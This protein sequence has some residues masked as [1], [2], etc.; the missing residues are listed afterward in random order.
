MQAHRIAKGPFLSESPVPQDAGHF[1]V[2]KFTARRISSE[3][4]INPE[5]ASITVAPLHS[6]QELSVASLLARLP[7][8][9]M[10]FAPNQTIYNQGDS[11]TRVYVVQSGAV[12]LCHHRRNGQRQI[13][14]LLLPE[15][16]LALF[17]SAEYG[18]TAEATTYSDVLSYLRQDVSRLREQDSFVERSI[19]VYAG[20]RLMEMNGRLIS[21]GY[22]SAE[23]RVATFLL[24]LSDRIGAN[25]GDTIPLPMNRQDFADYLGLTIETVCRILSAMRRRGDITL[26]HRHGVVIADMPAL[27][28]ISEGAPARR[29]TSKPDRQPTRRIPSS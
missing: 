24:E 17:D 8:R 4:E 7:G 11:A 3:V 16:I 5:A 29:A 15:D 25:E 9:S 13:M 27:K 28:L 26:T 1:A 19:L 23:Q 20:S 14:S 6:P 2:P 12:R 10:R 21:L 18:H 22:Q